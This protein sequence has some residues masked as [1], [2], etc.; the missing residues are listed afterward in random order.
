MGREGRHIDPVEYAELESRLTALGAQVRRQATPRPA[1]WFDEFLGD[2]SAIPA[3]AKGMSG[4]IAAGQDPGEARWCLRRRDKSWS[5]SH[6]L[7]NI[8][9]A[10]R[11]GDAIEIRGESAPLDDR[12]ASPSSVPQRALTSPGPIRVIADPRR[13]QCRKSQHSTPR[14]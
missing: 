2:G 6:R 8:W 5:V 11:T 1:G 13:R 4:R 10:S 12:G 14:G 9:S 3:T 7:V